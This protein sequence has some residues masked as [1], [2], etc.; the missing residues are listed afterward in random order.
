M[1]PEAPRTAPS[2]Q[3]RSSSG[4]PRPPTCWGRYPRPGGEPRV[5]TSSGSD[6]SQVTLIQCNNHEV[7]YDDIVRRFPPEARAPFGHWM[8]P[9]CPVSAAPVPPVQAERWLH[10]LWWR[11]RLLHWE[12]QHRHWQQQYIHQQREV[13][14]QPQQE[15]PCAQHQE[16]D[17]AKEWGRYKWNC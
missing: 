15:H 2:G 12:Q 8:S 9:H 7:Y 3:P 17:G 6:Q 11:G 4:P 13:W 10:H 16:Q 5:M 14:E 1:F